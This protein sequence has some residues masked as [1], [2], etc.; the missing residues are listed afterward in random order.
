VYEVILGA[1]LGAIMLASYFLLKLHVAEEDIA[2]AT[3]VMNMART[4]GGCIS[5]S[6]CTALLHNSIDN[7][8]AH[9][10]TKAQ[11]QA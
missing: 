5:V 1:G 4:L 7:G 10:L 9:D 11:L 6:A 3:G 8:L 2:S